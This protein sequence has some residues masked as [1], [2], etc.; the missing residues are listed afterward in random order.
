MVDSLHRTKYPLHS[1]PK[2]WKNTDTCSAPPAVIASFP[3][4]N[5]VNPQ[6]HG[7]A[8]IVL[9]ILLSTIGILV[10]GTR[11]Y[12][13]FYI[14]KAPGVDDL[15]I[16]GAL[17]S[18]IASSVLVIIGNTKYYSGHHVWDIPPDT[19]VGHRLNVWLSQLF[20]T[21]ALSCVK[22]SVLLFYR[23]LS[24]SFSRTF[25]IATWVGIA[26][27]VAYLLGFILTLL[28]LC[29]PL[30]AY[31]LTFD[32]TWPRTHAY[33]CGSEQIAEPL[34]ALFSVIG[35][36]YSAMLPMILVSRLSMP[37]KQK[38]AL[39][40]L[41][42]LAFLVVFVGLIRAV[43]LYRIVNV[44]YDFTWTLWTIWVLGAIELWFAV[45]AASAPALK[46]FLKRYIADKLPTVHSSLETRNKTYVVRSNGIGGLGKVEEVY[47]APRG[48]RAWSPASQ[49]AG[50]RNV[51]GR[52]KDTVK[53][54]QDAGPRIVCGRCVNTAKKS[55]AYQYREVELGLQQTRQIE[56]N[57]SPDGKFATPPVLLDAGKPNLY[58]QLP[59]E[60]TSKI[61]AMANGAIR[62][63]THHP[64]G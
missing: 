6:T 39:H 1:P 57:S 44:G 28:L 8:L 61:T 25:I 40:L 27:N 49:D 53:K 22:V 12:A 5:Y 13:R 36:F 58:K 33:S 47:A 14:T 20:F 2:I 59:R 7:P 64:K 15:L 19:A 21:I 60:P 32:Q 62:V 46:P 4:P 29:R 56:G 17:I 9:A 35:D 30:A 31:W 55:E 34:S 38:R 24:V 50:S 18:G 48:G 45:F 52:C 37:K 41:F 26:Y 11:L 3:K 51:C 10:V 42:S 43:Y 23:R 54:I 16:V 63:A